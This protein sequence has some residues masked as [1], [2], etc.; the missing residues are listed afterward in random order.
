MYYVVMVELQI[1]LSCVNIFKLTIR[2]GEN[3]CIT[4]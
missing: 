3:K 2:F 4:L 1:E